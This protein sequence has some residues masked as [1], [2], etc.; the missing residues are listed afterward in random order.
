[1]NKTLVVCGDSFNYGIGCRDLTT[2]PYG[3]KTAENLGWNCIRLARGSASNYAIHLQGMYAATNLNPKPDLVILGTTSYDR[4]EWVA[5]GK[6]LNQEPTLENLNYHLYP[7]HN[8]AQPLHDSPMPYYLE[9]SQRYDPK[10]LSEQVVA[11]QDY[12]RILSKDRNN[13]YYKRL[14]SEPKPKLELI[15]QFY[16]EIYNEW[17]KRDYDVGVIML[18]YRKIKKAG[19][20]CIIAGPDYKYYDFV[21][22]HTD[23]FPINW[24]QLSREYPDTVNTLHCSEEAHE[25][26]S[27]ALT[28]HIKIHKFI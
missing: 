20:N 25:L 10:I 18:A 22:G 3:I 13:E 2:Q 23:F 16:F 1:M 9:N 11:F 4:I 27:Q 14:R 28:N 21:D 24:G 26:I 17:I 15:D 12:F 6:E 7:P 8:M 19:I 5:E